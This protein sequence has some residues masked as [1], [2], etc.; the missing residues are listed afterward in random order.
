MPDYSS[1]S[2]SALEV[3]YFSLYALQQDQKPRS[4]IPSPPPA[5][6]K[7]KPAILA[8]VII[9]WRRIYIPELTVEGSSQ[10][11]NLKKQKKSVVPKKKK[12]T[13]EEIDELLS[14][15]CLEDESFYMR[16]LRYEPFKLSVFESKVADAVRI[17]NA[18]PISSLI[19]SKWFGFEVR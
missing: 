9:L 15:V 18:K 8:R 11:S 3:E 19:L 17:E 10:V 16:I 12:L 14:R 6:P 7:T 2:K 4:E 1:Y 5:L 13:S